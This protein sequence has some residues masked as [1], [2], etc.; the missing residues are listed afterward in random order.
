MRL[1]N[2]LRVRNQNPKPKTPFGLGPFTIHR[3]VFFFCFQITVRKISNPFPFPSFAQSPRFQSP[4][5]TIIIILYCCNCLLDFFQMLRYGSVTITRSFSSQEQSLSE[6]REVKICNRGWSCSN[7]KPSC[8]KLCFSSNRCT[9]LACSPQLC[10]R[11][12]FL[13]IL[14]FLFSPFFF[15]F[16]SFFFLRFQLRRIFSAEFVH[17]TSIAFA[18]L[19]LFPWKKENRACGWAENI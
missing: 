14:L 8:S 6:S 16:F 4:I 11:L 7:N 2:W 17:P 13:C 5:S 3:L 12:A 19:F 9:T 15:L 1:E 18:A 10:L